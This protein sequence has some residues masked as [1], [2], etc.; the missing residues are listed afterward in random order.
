MSELGSSG[1]EVSDLCLGGNVFGWTAD[2]AQS[3]RILDRFVEAGGDF[4]DTADRYSSWVDGNRG[5]ESETVIGHWLRRRGRRDDVVIATKVGQLEGF[6]GLSARNIEL[7]VEA[8]LSRLQTDYVDLYYAHID[9]REVP[10]DETLG[11]FDALVATGKVRCIGASNYVASRLS[12]ALTISRERGWNAYSVLQTHYNLVHRHEFEDDLAD[13][14]AREGILCVAYSALAD[15]F[16]TGKYRRGAEPPASA[17]ADDVRP[18]LTA[19]YDAVLDALDEVAE[20]HRV[21]VA[22][23][24]LAWLSAHDGVVALASARTTGQLDDLVQ[25]VGLHLS[26]AEMELLDARTACLAP[27]AGPEAGSD[28]PKVGG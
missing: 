20:N 9:D 28:L 21:A 22:A 7:A 2:E 4:I 19:E 1:I 13:L 15:G 11:A 17:R 12:D 23:V 18:Y 14:C 6:E 26:D 8:S 24:A 3:H 5:G 10:L 16:L 25:A 27:D